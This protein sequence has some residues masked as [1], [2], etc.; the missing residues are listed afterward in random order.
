[1]LIGRRSVL[2]IQQ[3]WG[4]TLWPSLNNRWMLI[5]CR[6][7]TFFHQDLLFGTGYPLVT[8]SL[9]FRSFPL[10]FPFDIKG[11][12]CELGSGLEQ[13]SFTIVELKIDFQRQLLELKFYFRQEVG[14]KKEKQDT[15]RDLYVCMLMLVHLRKNGLNEKKGKNKTRHYITYL[16]MSVDYIQN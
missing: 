12:K 9:T 14:F 3:D 8:L 2:R 11:V 16:V 6:A 15:K 10:S 4:L 5:W 1:M 13:K 7:K